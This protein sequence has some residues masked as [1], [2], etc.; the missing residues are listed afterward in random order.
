MIDTGSWAFWRGTLALVIGSFMVFANVYVTQPLLPMIAHEF[1][2]SE[3][4]AASSFTITTLTLG[5]SLLFYGPL[6]DAL[7]R[8]NIMIM[9][10]LGVTLTTFSLGFVTQYSELLLLRALQGFFLAGLPAIA[11][12]YLGD[13][14]RPQAMAVAVGLYISGNTIGGIGGRLIGGFVGEWQGPSA[15][16]FV[17]SVFSMVCFF[18]FWVLLPNSENFH[19]KRFR[20]ATLFT[21]VKLHISNPIL[22]MCYLIG[23]FNFFIFIN[24]YS[25]I[26]FVLEA[27]PYSL[28]ASYVSL[29]F[30]TYLTGTIGSAFSGKLAV[31]YSQPK[32]MA[33]GTL[34]LMLGSAITLYGSLTSIIIG[35]LINCFGFFLC[36]STASSFVSKNAHQAKASASS[37][38]LVFYYLGASVGG[39][40]L[41][42]FWQAGGWIGVVLGSWLILSGVFV[43]ALILSQYHRKQSTDSLTANAV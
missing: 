7:G 42:P 43:V 35:L 41:D 3:L 10:L 1:S 4:Q 18:L 37:L 24:Q 34:I 36:H 19:A 20:P 40:Y 29:L 12:A 22:L 8:K 30:L 33:L 39:F 17:M 25:Y 28:S 9:A 23:G 38:Y 11:V 16:F 13:E 15:A 2:I 32:I 5:L 27:E 31:Y 6:S 14:Y 21:N 26:T